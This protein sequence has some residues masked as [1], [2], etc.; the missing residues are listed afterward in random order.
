M[1]GSVDESFDGEDPFFVF[2][3]I[4]QQHIG[5]FMN[6]RYDDDI[7]VGNIFGMPQGAFPFNN[8]HVRVH[9][10]PTD[11]FQQQQ[12]PQHE[13]HKENIKNADEDIPHIKNIFKNLFK[14]K[15]VIH[16]KP[17]NIIY[18]VNVSF[19]DIYNMKKKK[20]SICRLRKRN[21]E[22]VEKKK[23]IEIPI[24]GR[25]I[26][27]EGEGHDMKNY[28]ERGDV[29]INIFNKE[30]PHFKRVNQY[31][32][33]TYKDIH[34]YEYYSAYVYE[35]VLPNGEVLKVQS[36]KFKNG[37]H[38]IQKIVGK[39]LPYKNED[40]KLVYGNMYVLY[41]II[42]PEKMEELKDISLMNYT[43]LIFLFFSFLTSSCNF[44]IVFLKWEGY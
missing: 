19:A 43:F 31:D 13:A 5:S 20:V 15:K 4:F 22:Y 2:N 14:D 26:I 17:D 27:L 18:N 9:T 28:S 35:L 21:G 7:N 40:N 41:K 6:M 16:G 1:L 36:E 37:K 24:Y 3:N 11:I 42:F 33:L 38:L 8:I 32:I 44:V 23:K 29:I 30:D 12:M 39:G 34:I 25:E 10:F